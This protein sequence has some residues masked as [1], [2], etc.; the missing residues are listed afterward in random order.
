MKFQP[1]KG[2][3]DFYPAEMRLREWLFERWRRTS[4][5]NGFEEYDGPIFESLDL[6]RAK[7]GDQI[8]SELFHFVDRG[9]REFALRPEMTPTL[10]RMVAARAPSM[11]KPIRWFSMPRLC[12]AERPQR[13]RLREF[14]Q[15]NVDVIGEDQPIADAECIFVMIDFLRDVGLTP[16]QVVLKINSRHLVVAILQSAGFAEE[17]M[18]PV[19][20]ALDKRD[21]LSADAFAEHVG[22]LGIDA[23]QRETLI[24]LGDAAGPDGLERVGKLAGN[25]S[26][27]RQALAT[28]TE[29]FALLTSMGVAEY[30]T[31]EMSVVRGLAYYTGVVFEA[32]G[33]GGLQRAICGGGRYDRLVSDLGG[34][35]MGGVGFATSDV[36][37]LDV[38]DEFN[39]LPDA[40]EPRGLFVID[41]GPDCFD[42]VLRLTG[43]LRRRN[44]PAIYSY[45]RQPLSKQIKQAVGRRAARVIIVEEPDAT[46]ERVAVKD[47]D[48]GVQRSI[49]VESLLADPFQALED[50]P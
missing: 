19:L 40:A 38:L 11:P 22:G 8:V 41:A 29:V 45:K 13:G 37:M 21:R 31:F 10:A 9:N 27:A 12:R 50:G 26:D 33:R 15:W 7:S 49:L 39:L 20:A 17:Q 43:E 48:T 46:A 16:D 2:C 34:P 23:R 42:R 24:H 30:C 36:V 1:P 6:Y 32:F 14:F 3:R 4:I 35:P 44:H 28:L 18:T 25:S 47:L 5:R